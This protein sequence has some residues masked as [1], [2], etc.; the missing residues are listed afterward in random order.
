MDVY[1]NIRNPKEGKPIVDMRQDEAGKAAREK[2]IA[3][4]YD[5]VIERDENGNIVEVLAFNSEQIKSTENI[6]AFD[7]NNPNIYLQEEKR[8]KGPAPWEKKLAADNAAWNDRFKNRPVVKKGATMAEK[9][10]F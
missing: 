1:L 8:S 7:P 2:L 5:G 3:E 4:G 6:G 10:P 9:K